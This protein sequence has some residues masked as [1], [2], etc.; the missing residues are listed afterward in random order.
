MTSTS[1]TRSLHHPDVQRRHRYGHGKLCS[2]PDTKPDPEVLAQAMRPDLLK[3]FKPALLGRITVIPYFPLDDD[4]MRNII[5][6]NP[7]RRS[8]T[9]C[10]RS[11]HRAAFTYDDALLNT[12]AGRCK[13]VESGARNVDHILTGTM[14]P[15]MSGEILNR[16]I[17]GR[18]IKS[19]HVT[20]AD[21]KFVYKID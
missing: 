5:R 14:L 9:V 11:N 13:E 4:M 7:G 15:E 2:D 10:A 12:I 20:A 17:E 21:G 6:L 18:A 19:V 3:A 8:P 1:R 16:T